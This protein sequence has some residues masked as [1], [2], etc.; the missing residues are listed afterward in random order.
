MMPT[1]VQTR[2]KSEAVAGSP[3]KGVI[4]HR[5]SAVATNHCRFWLYGL[6][7]AVWLLSADCLVADDVHI[8]SVAA[9][10]AASAIEGD[11]LVESRDAVIHIQR[12]GD[13]F[14]GHIVWQLR[15]TYG[16]EDGPALNGKIVTDR[17]NPDPARRSQPLTGSRLLWGL[18][19]DPTRQKW[20]DGQV[21]DA[22]NG[23]TFHCQIRLIDPDR[24]KLRGY[25]GFSL[26]GG[27]SV[28]S[29]V[30]MTNP[31]HGEPP[32]VMHTTSG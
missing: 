18:R 1:G 15:D 16:P 31:S 20:V 6:A 11:W 22:D 19:Y 30:A 27:N 29:R 4:A 24:L 25:I 28:W 7:C 17:N 23:R 14:E 21:Y 26:L 13:R 2:R 9:N 8:D 5:W 32:Y 10:T 3:P 12:V